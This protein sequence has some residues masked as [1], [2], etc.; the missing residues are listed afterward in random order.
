MTGSTLRCGAV[1]GW[2]LL[3]LAVG[4]ASAR[5]QTKSGTEVPEASTAVAAGTETTRPEAAKNAPATADAGKADPEKAEPEKANAGKADPGKAVAGRGA[6]ARAGKQA[7]KQKAPDGKEPADKAAA[8]ATATAA[9]AAAPTSAGQ[10]VA[11]MPPASPPVAPNPTEGDRTALIDQDV[12]Q[13]PPQTAIASRDPSHLRTAKMKLGGLLDRSVHSL[14]NNEV[15]RVIDVMTGDD[16]KPAALELDVGGF[17]GVGN[18]R[19]A[20]AWNLFDLT[21]TGQN[22]PLRVALSAAQVRSAPAMDESGETQVVTGAEPIGAP[23]PAK[24]AKPDASQ[25]A[26]ASAPGSAVPAPGGPAKAAPATT[27][28]VATTPSTAAPGSA[29]PAP[30]GA[31]VPGGQQQAAPAEPAKPAQSRD[32]TPKQDGTAPVA[33]P[34]A[35]REAA[36]PSSDAHGATGDKKPAAHPAETADPAHEDAAHRGARDAS[37]RDGNGEPRF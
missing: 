23:A 27:T 14:E 24:D 5:A 32:A 15:G 11:S 31:G 8:A 33:K 35:P 16:G 17:L 19:I 13:H 25:G 10:G 28:P 12:A 34:G 18:R 37:P 4:D 6:E 9:G 3:S 21:R 29:A 1:L 22:D 30:T 36:H 26:G 20:V 7:S 2:T